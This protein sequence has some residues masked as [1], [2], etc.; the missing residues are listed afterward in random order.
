MIGQ[1]AC[2]LLML[3]GC[4]A[5]CLSVLLHRRH[6]ELCFDQLCSVKRG[7]VRQAMQV[8]L[9][10]ADAVWLCCHS[11]YQLVSS[12]PSFSLSSAR[13]VAPSNTVRHQMAKAGGRGDAPISLF[14]LSPCCSALSPFPGT[15]SLPLLTHFAAHSLPANNIFPFKSHISNT[16][17]YRHMYFQKHTK[18]SRAPNM[19][20]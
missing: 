20:I 5:L 17:A 9:L 2:L 14:P 16:G 15:H 18:N 8:S 3:A 13:M 10:F 1:P 11:S 19:H 7:R 4:R 6:L 12:F